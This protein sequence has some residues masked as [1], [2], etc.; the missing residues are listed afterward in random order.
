MKD[1]VLS[2]VFLMYLNLNSLKV[3]YTINVVLYER[4]NYEKQIY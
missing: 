3:V 1:I 4:Y 2:Y